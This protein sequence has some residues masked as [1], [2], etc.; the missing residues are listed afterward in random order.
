MSHDIAVS[1]FLIIY[2]HTKWIL[3]C[4][5]MNNNILCHRI[6]S[7][8]F[9]IFFIHYVY[10]AESLSSTDNIVDMNLLYN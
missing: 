5:S 3:S 2:T 9:R 6:I 8:E 4:L 1:Y 7:G 10:I